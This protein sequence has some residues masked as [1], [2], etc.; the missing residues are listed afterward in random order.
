MGLQRRVLRKKTIYYLYQE[1]AI[2][3]ARGSGTEGYQAEFCA[4]KQT[5]KQNKISDKFK[6]QKEII[7]RKI[8]TSTFF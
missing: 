1:Y 3:F 5:I 8:Y 7:E 2:L 6:L 4:C